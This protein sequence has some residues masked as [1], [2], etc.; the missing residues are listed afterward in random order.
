MEQLFRVLIVGS[1]QARAALCHTEDF[2]LIPEVTG[3]EGR[4]PFGK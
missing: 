1:G 2:I 4:Y 3:F